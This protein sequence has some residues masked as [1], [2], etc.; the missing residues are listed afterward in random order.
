MK[1]FS[2]PR[3]IVLGTFACCALATPQFALAQP[4]TPAAGAPK[5][6]KDKPAGKPKADNKK[7]RGKMMM[8][9]VVEATE[10]AMGKPLTPELKEQLNQAMRDRDAAVKAANDAYYAAFVQATGL[11]AEQAK[12]IDKPARGGMNGG[13][14]AKAPTTPKAE[15]KTNMDELTEMDDTEA[16]PVTPG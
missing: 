10:A 11:T 7:P 14:G 5:A 4:K 3:L 6:K 12:E 13:K 9:R 1:I 8:P 2:S 16:A 15:V